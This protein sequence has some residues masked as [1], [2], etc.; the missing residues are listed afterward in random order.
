MKQRNAYSSFSVKNP[1]HINKHVCI[2]QLSSQKDL[3]TEIL[4]SPK[5]SHGIHNTQFIK[6]KSMKS[7]VQK[8]VTD[9]QSIPLITSTD[10]Y[11]NF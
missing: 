8:S 10:S 2:P 11:C 3:I 1:Q 6:K 9:D 7:M 4:V 5:T